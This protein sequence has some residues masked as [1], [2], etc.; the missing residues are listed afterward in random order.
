MI[1]TFGDTTDVT[2]WR[3]LDLPTRAVVGRDGRLA[4]RRRRRGRRPTTAA[5]RA[6]A[7]LAGKTVKQR[8]ERDRS[9]CSARPGDLLG[10][11]KPI[12][13]PVK[14]YEK[15]D[16]ARSRS[17]PPASGTSATAAATPTCARR[18]STGASELDWHP[19]YMRHRYDNWVG[20][21]NGDWLI[22][23]QRFFGVPIPVWYRLDA[24]GEPRLR[25][26][27]RCPTRPT[28]PVDPSIRRAAR[29]R[30][31][32]ARPA[33]RLRR[34]PRRHGHLGHVVAHAADRRRLGRRPRPVRP[35]LP[36]G[37]AP[38][39]PRHHPHL[40]VL[41]GRA[42]P[43]RARRAARGPTPPSRAGSSTP[44]ARRC[45]SRRA[46]SSRPIGLLEQ[47]GSDA[48]RY[49][50][51]SARPGTDTALR[52]GPDEGRPPPRHQAAQRLASSRC[53]ASARARRP[54][55]TPRRH[56]AARPGAARRPGRR[57]S[58]RPPTAF[59][60]YDYAR[61][62]ERTEAFF[63]CVLRRLPRAGQGPR[64]RQRRTP[65]RG[66]RLGPGRARARP[67]TSSCACSRRSCP[68]SPRRSGRGGGGVGPPGPVARP[69]RAGSGR[70]R[71]RSP[72]PGWPAP[73]SARCAGP[74]PRPRSRCAPT[75]SVA[76]HRLRRAA[77]RAGAG[78]RRRP[79]RR[80]G[81]RPCGP[82][83]TT[84]SRS[85]V[86]PRPRS[87]RANS[88]PRLSAG[89]GLAG[90]GRT[91]PRGCGARGCA[92]GR[93]SRCPLSSRRSAIRSWSSR[94]TAY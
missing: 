8:P 82:R 1:C 21:L 48:V 60:G 89:A 59:E 6:T 90:E 7:E 12:T 40:A 70:G 31:G 67:S 66:G 52:R 20:G 92:G 54:A 43:L 33:G 83:R 74:R 26:A 30:R 49:W 78:R 51:A 61:A 84:P 19:R 53:S 68:S 63:W 85:S 47:Y 62:L 91:R 16:R 44:T 50:A 35:H 71:R 29:L 87:P 11:P 94:V 23:R 45:R 14:F 77:G 27:D 15:G 79:G 34:R 80:Q 72:G 86:A 55:A 2:W 58:T 39:G 36:D 10:E 64:L 65:R 73:S 56:R 5:R 93:G 69:D 4:R 88:A 46:T 32:P 42:R 81:R 37:P 25:P 28:L 76:R 75:S 38:A 41:H 24:D 17:S 57:W 18:S 22:S 9:S 3:E 13:H